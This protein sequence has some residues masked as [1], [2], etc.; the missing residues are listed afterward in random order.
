[1]ADITTDINKIKEAVYGEE[2][3]G[4]IVNALLAMNEQAEEAEEWATGNESGGTPSATNNAKYYAERAQQVVNDKVDK[5][6]GKGLST[7]DYTDEEKDAVGDI[8]DM[9]Q[10]IN[11]KVDKVAGKGLSTND[12]T[13]EDLSALDNIKT[14]DTTLTLEGK[15]ADAHATGEALSELDD[16]KANTDGYYINL[17]SGNA[18]QM[19]TNIGVEDSVPYNFRTA[20]GSAEIGNRVDETVVGGSL[21]WNQLVNTPSSDVSKIQNNITFTDNRDGTFTVQTTEEGASADTYINWTA[22]F[23]PISEHKYLFAGT[24]K[25]GSISTYY[26]YLVR[27]GAISSGQDTGNGCIYNGLVTDSVI[28]ISVVLMI[29]SGTVV[30][31]PIKFVPQTHDLTAMFG[32]EIADYI[33]SLEQATAGAGVSWF[34]KLFPKDYYTYNAGTMVHVQTSAHETVGFNQW[35]EEW[36]LGSYNPTTGAPVTANTS[37]RS[38]NINPIPVFPNTTYCF[39]RPVNNGAIFAYWYDAEGNYISR[40]TGASTAEMV[41][42]ESPANARFLRFALGEGYGATYKNDVCVNLSYDGSRNGE[43]E[44][45]VKHTYPLDDSLTLRG[46]PKLDANDKL[47]FDGDIYSADGTV[48]R[49]YG[50]VDLGTLNWSY[51]LPGTVFLATVSNLLYVAGK[52]DTLFCEK[53]KNAPVQNSTAPD[54]TIYTRQ[55]VGSDPG[56]GVKDSAYTDAAAFKTAMSGVYLVYELAEPTTE[57]V[58]P[59]QSPQIVDD[60]GTERYVDYAYEAG[61]RDFEVPVGHDSFYQANLKAKLEMSPNSPSGDGDYI[62]RQIGGINTYVPLEEVR[63]LPTPPSEDGTYTLKATVSGGV[64]TLSWVAD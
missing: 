2:V 34:R 18:D 64:A 53:Y 23:H 28:N 38:K 14:T 56:I 54:K 59:F 24:P 30:T 48:Q 33:Y 15:A 12:F 36:E 61:D 26:S 9:K 32:T 25:S 16:K 17:T 7:N 6:A 22:P 50:I 31:S 62:V 10:A 43:Y 60:F 51:S 5:V 8:S 45:Y 21:V 40:N 13:D 47:Y 63:E 39:A 4:A 46:I 55:T 11:N 19:T 35:D 1:M 42:A 37:I 29:K 49:R 20:G 3:R 41:V 27:G 57:T 44:P 58:D 52:R